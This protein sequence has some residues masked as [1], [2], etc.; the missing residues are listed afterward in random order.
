MSDE[1]AMTTTEQKPF[2]IPDEDSRPY[3]DNAKQG[4]LVYWSCQSCGNL[5]QQPAL[6][7][8][9]CRGQEFE[10]QQVSGRGTIFSF[11]IARQTTTVGFAD[12]V[13]Y[14]VVLVAIDEQPDLVVLAN[15]VGA[16][17]VLDQLD[18]GLPVQVTFEARGEYAVPQFGLVR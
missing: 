18:I 6:V 1:Q 12:D 9:R 13:P 8:S 15:L 7:C 16:D 17:I 4:R 5:T 2:P 10:W 11:A 3:W 14:V